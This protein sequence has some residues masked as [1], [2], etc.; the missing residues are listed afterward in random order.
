[1][2][3]TLCATSVIQAG[4]T[5]IESD[6]WNHARLEDS[7]TKKK[8]EEVEAARTAAEEAAEEAVAKV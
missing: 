2:A 1:M 6:G 3:Q 8:R 5:A 4:T 7:T